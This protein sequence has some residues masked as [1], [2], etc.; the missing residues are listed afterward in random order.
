MFH[1]LCL[2]HKEYFYLYCTE[3]TE[4]S[5]TEILKQGRIKPEIYD[6][7]SPGVR[8][9][10]SEKEKNS[11]VI[12]RLIFTTVPHFEETFLGLAMRRKK[13]ENILL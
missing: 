7:I 4:I 9:V 11:N 3:V 8:T 12:K 2:F 5:E 6:K 10:T 1:S 13:Q